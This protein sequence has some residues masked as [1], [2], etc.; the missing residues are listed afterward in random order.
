MLIPTEFH[1]LIAAALRSAWPRLTDV[2]RSYAAEI[3][4]W[5][6]AVASGNDVPPDAKA[7]GEDQ[8]L[9]WW[10]GCIEWCHRIPGDA[11]QRQSAEVDRHLSGLLYY[12]LVGD[13]V[14]AVE[15]A[16]ALASRDARNTAF[17]S[18]IVEVAQAYA[19]APESVPRWVR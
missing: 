1:T 19:T 8:A 9:A 6:E 2:G 16:L 14:R 10:G 11:D 4:P 5:A 15:C 17:L 3:Y 13:G 12:A 18:V 7:Q